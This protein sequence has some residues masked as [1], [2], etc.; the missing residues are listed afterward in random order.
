MFDFSADRIAIFGGSGFIGTNMIPVLLELGATIRNFDIA[1]CADPRQEV[2]RESVDGTIGAAVQSALDDFQPTVII[3]LAARTDCA[4]D[5]TVESGY[6]CNINIVRNI[7]EASRLLN[8]RRVIFTSTQYVCGPDLPVAHSEQYAPH[9]VYGQSKVEMEQFVK[10]RGAEL[11]WTI[12]RPTIVWGPWHEGQSR[13]LLKLLDIGAYAHP[14]KA[15]GRKS[16]CYVGN[17]VHAYAHILA[18]CNTTV[19]S[20]VFYGVDEILPAREWVERFYIAFHNRSLPLMPQWLGCLGALA[21]DLITA[22]RGNEFYLTSRKLASMGANHLVPLEGE[23]HL[24]LD[25]PYCSDEAVSITLN[26]YKRWRSFSRG[27][28]L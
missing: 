24:S 23:M 28:Q 13:G 15:Q 4:E 25:H 7:I 11:P 18:S 17:L 5:T 1:N 9:T 6:A 16:Y 19:N 14:A 2:W 21:G 3:D 10:Q 20:R 22:A 27:A 12:M 26:W 8:L